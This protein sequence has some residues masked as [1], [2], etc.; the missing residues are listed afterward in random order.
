VA[1]I[2]AGGETPVVPPLIV[3]CSRALN[4]Y[5]RGPASATNVELMTVCPDSHVT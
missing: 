5:T 4:E 1:V 2:D 3:L